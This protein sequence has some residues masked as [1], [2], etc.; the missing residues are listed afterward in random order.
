MLELGE[1]QRV[2]AE[3][4]EFLDEKRLLLAAELLRQLERYELLLDEIEAL[5]RGA[6]QQL[7]AAVQRHGLQEL[8][9]YPATPLVG[10]GIDLQQRNVMGVTLLDARLMRPDADHR[11][12]PVASQPSPEAEQCRAAFAGF[13]EDPA[14]LGESNDDQRIQE[15]G[16]DG[17][18]IKQRLLEVLGADDPW[19]AR[20]PRAYAPR[21]S[22]WSHRSGLARLALTALESRGRKRTRSTPL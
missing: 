22:A 12:P 1:E 20:A 16:L 19:I 11:M 6:R 14:Y 13:D 5:V 18:L 21:G 9:V 10:V 7:V 4:Y 15:R 17:R 2:V 3:A 8:S